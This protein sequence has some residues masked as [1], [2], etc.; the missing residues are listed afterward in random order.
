M[1]PKSIACWKNIYENE[2]HVH[3]SPT[4]RVSI[5]TQGCVSK[6]L[7][8]A[9]VRH[10]L[11][12]A[13]SLTSPFPHTTLLFIALSHLIACLLLLNRI[14]LGRAAVGEI[15]NYRKQQLQSL[16]Q[17]SAF[18]AVLIPVNRRGLHSLSLFC[19]LSPSS[20]AASFPPVRC[21]QRIINCL[22]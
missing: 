5:K 18:L 15:L 22:T 6:C 13:V 3:P 2:N 21:G 9:G 14:L 7:Q 1:S 11:S 12:R 19:C 4:F 16:L 17:N 8:T 10:L 20:G